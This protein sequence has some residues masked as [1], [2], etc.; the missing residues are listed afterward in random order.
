VG[1]CGEKY[2]FTVG[3]EEDVFVDEE[4]INCQLHILVKFDE[5]G[6]YLGDAL[7]HLLSIL[8]YRLPIHFQH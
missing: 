4:D 2:F 3:G 5:L 7:H 8:P 6:W 1:D